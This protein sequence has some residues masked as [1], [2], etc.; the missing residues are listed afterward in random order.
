MTDKD[1]LIKAAQTILNF[2]LKSNCLNCPCW[3]RVCDK[4]GCLDE[5]AREIIAR[6]E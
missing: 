1:E 2:C 3:D 6:F 4:W 5:V